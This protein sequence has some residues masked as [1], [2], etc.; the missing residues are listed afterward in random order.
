MEEGKKEEREGKL[1]KGIGKRRM[2][3]I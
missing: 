2:E 3:G 1:E